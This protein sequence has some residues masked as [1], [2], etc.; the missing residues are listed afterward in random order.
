MHPGVPAA[1]R[2]VHLATLEGERCRLEGDGEAEQRAARQRAVRALLEVGQEPGVDPG[3]PGQLL[4]AQA[5]LVAAVGDPPGQVPGQ[6]VVAG[7]CDAWA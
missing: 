7:W 6:G 4:G 2:A 1:R 3:P 5:E